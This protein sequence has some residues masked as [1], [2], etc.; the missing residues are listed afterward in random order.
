MSI[1]QRTSEPRWAARRS[2]GRSKPAL[3]LAERWAAPLAG[4]VVIAIMSWPLVLLP[5]SFGGDWRTHSWYVA[6]QTRSLLDD[7]LPTLF[8]NVDNASFYPHYAFYGGTLYALAGLLSIVLGGVARNGYV[9]SWILASSAG[10]VGWV[11]LGRMAG[12]G[13]WTAQVPAVVFLTSP[14][15]VTMAYV[16]GDWPEYVAVSSIPLLAASAV[17]VLRSDRLRPLAM[18]A[19]AGSAITFSGSHNITLLWG[20]AFFLILVAALCA[21][22]PAARRQVSRRGVARVLVVLVPAV[23]VNAWFLLPDVAY[24]AQTQIAQTYEVARGYVREAGALVA[25]EYLFGLRRRPAQPGSD[26]VV[27]LP[28]LAMAWALAGGALAGRRP[29]GRT[30]LRVYGLMAVVAAVFLVVMTHVGLLLALPKPFVMIQFSYRLESYVLLAISGGVLVAL[31]LLRDATGWR[32]WWPWALVPVLAWS[33]VGGVGQVGRYGTVAA[34]DTYRQ[35]IIGSLGDFADASTRE[36]A[37]GGRARVTFPLEQI[38]HDRVTITATASPGQLLDTDLIVMPALIHVDGA[39]IV[40]MVTAPT[41]TTG[42]QRHAVLQ[43]DRDAT[44][45]AAKIT[46]R[47]AQP[48][49]VAIGRLLS[50]LGLVGLLA[51]FVGAVAGAWRARSGRRRR[52]ESGG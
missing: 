3:R 39:R 6:H 34:I 10:Y 4:A 40:G 23:L 46:V 5:D 32:R 37:P 44:P 36:I 51:G 20:S 8:L 48:P 28:V 52:V 13:R 24:Q 29:W 33:V 9:V 31:V 19:L 17:S 16:R 38:H 22:V 21:C 42:L 1:A 15:L 27:T 47:A 11:W 14:Y 12:L 43:V 26:F 2:G 35:P 18:M 7:H 30:W 45:G 50:V 25:H 41:N 49:A